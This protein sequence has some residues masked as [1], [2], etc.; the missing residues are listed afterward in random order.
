VAQ[1][2]DAETELRIAEV[3]LGM[4]AEDFVRSPIGRYLLGRAQI[5][6]DDATTKLKRVSPA[7]TEAVRALQNRVLLMESFGGWIQDAIANGNNAEAQLQ[8]QDAIGEI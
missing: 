5:E 3:R 2:F 7:D 6:V 1:Q 4:Q 8:H